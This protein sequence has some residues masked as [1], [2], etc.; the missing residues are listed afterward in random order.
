MCCVA[1][2]DVRHMQYML[3][4][5]CLQQEGE[6]PDMEWWDTFIISKDS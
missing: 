5:L 3:V 6:V 1:V 4:L 2:G